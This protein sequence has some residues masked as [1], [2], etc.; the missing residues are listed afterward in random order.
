MNRSSISM[1]SPRGERRIR[2]PTSHLFI[3]GLL[4]YI[5]AFQ[6]V[7]FTS[8]SPSVIESQGYGEDHNSIKATSLQSHAKNATAEAIQLLKHLQQRHVPVQSV[9]SFRPIAWRRQSKL[10]IKVPY[11]IFVTSLPKTGTT[12]IFKYFRC[13]GVRSSHNWVSQPG[14]K[15][16][17]TAGKCIQANIVAGFPPFE[18]CGAVDLFSDTGVRSVWARDESLNRLCPWKLTSSYSAFSWTVYRLRSRHWSQ[19]LLS[20]DRWL[21]RHLQCL[22]QCHLC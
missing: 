4:V 11:P 3:I 10:E 14:T 9:Q 2:W 16:T 7:V 18:G 12:S 1:S 17:S 8:H 6:T 21:G 19:V 5:A 22:S 15:K 13:G 20:V